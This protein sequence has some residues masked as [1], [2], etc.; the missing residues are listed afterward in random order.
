[1]HCFRTCGRRVQWAR[2][3]TCD[4]RNAHGT[5]RLK[6]FFKKF[7]TQLLRFSQKERS[8]HVYLPPDCSPD[9]ESLSRVNFI[10]TAFLNFK[11]PEDQINEKTT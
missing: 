6:D 1:M 2:S 9:S 11:N 8:L 5:S 3:S 7:L 4:Y 10:R